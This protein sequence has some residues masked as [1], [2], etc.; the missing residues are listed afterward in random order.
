MDGFES[1]RK[2]SGQVPAVER[3]IALLRY[4]EENVAPSAC[5][6][7]RI[8]A[9][10]GLHKSTTSNILRT[11]RA[12]GLIA[13]D[14]DSKSFRLGAELIGLGM[15]AANRRDSRLIELKHLEALVRDTRYS[16]VIVEQLPNE[17][18]L[19][20]AKVDAFH[21]IKVTIDIGQHFPP[22]APA[23][24]RIAMAW[25]PI[26]DARA[27]FTRWPPPPATPNAVTGLD[28]NLAELAR[29]RQRGYAVSVGEYYP[30]NTAISAPIFA[31]AGAPCRGICLVS[32]T[33]ELPKI[34][35]PEVGEKLRA[36]AA[37][38]SRELGATPPG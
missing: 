15:S 16:C 29:V 9:A 38:I 7:T 34:R 3:A 30:S 27:Y 2:I 35:I 10:L 28:A 37:A 24:A 1:G 23:L 14:P 19:V 8:A 18:F 32:F 31:Q 11:L 5:T 33:S 25:R 26:E 12:G 13:Y 20:V 17:Q 22:W 6:V 4:L 21:E 36:A